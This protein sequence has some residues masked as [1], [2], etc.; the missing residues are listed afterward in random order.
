MEA[1]EELSAHVGVTKACDAL[2]VARASFYRWRAPTPEKGERPSPP[3]ALSREEREKVRAVLDSDEFVDQAPAQVYAKL[4]ERG[5]YL[6][7]PRTM[8]RILHEYGEVKERRDQLRHPEYT[9]PELLATGVNQVWSWDITKLLGP[10]K[11]TYYY[12]YV[13]LD[14]FSR[15]VVGWLVAERESAELAERLI[16]ETV[17]KYAL[18]GQQLTLHADR[19]PSMRS[20]LVAQLLGELGI[21]KSHSRPYTSADNPYSEAHFKTLKY[22]PAFPKRFGSLEDARSFLRVFFAWYN[23]EHRHSGLAYL[24]PAVV[25]FGREQEVQAVQQ[26]AL[27]AAYGR[28]P[29]RFVHGRPMVQALPEAVWINPPCPKAASRERSDREQS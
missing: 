14:L 16:A 25:H 26:E 28:N 7:A 13:I 22:R 11:W 9:K 21:T 27:D 3:R 29:E 12:L 10:Q 2:G 18:D 4:L 17:G 15:Y 1:V 20:K 8:Y 19:G 5:E 24:T 23:E 6:C